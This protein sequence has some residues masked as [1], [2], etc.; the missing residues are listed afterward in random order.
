MLIIKKIL[1]SL[2]ALAI[3]VHPAFTQSIDKTIQRNDAKIHYKIFG[4]G[5]PILILAGGPGFS[6]KYITPVA[7]ELSKSYQCILIDQRGTGESMVNIYD[8]SSITISKTIE[9]IEFLKKWLQ[10]SRWIV[11]GHS[12]GG[13]LASCYIA[14]FPESISSLIL[15][16]GAGFNT[17]MWSYFD[18][19]INSKLLPSDMQVIAYW[20]D[21]SRLISDPDRSIYEIQKASTPGYFYDREK[22]LIFSQNFTPDEWNLDVWR[23]IWEDMDDHKLDVTQASKNVTQSVLILQGRQDPIGATVPWILNHTYPNSRFFFIEK[24]GHLPWIEQPEVFYRRI[25]DFLK[26]I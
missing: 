17:D 6:M 9:D 24:C 18:D 12:Y 16:G 2:I 1:F 19:N 15:I 21:S 3:S 25:A 14:K 5:K 13:I 23:L 11:L 7:E 22:S 4:E 10:I 26:D 20:N 8:S